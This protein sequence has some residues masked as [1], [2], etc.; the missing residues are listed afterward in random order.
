[1]SSG[2]IF[3]ANPGM[4]DSS[5]RYCEICGIVECAATKSS[6]CPWPGGATSCVFA[7]VRGG[8]EC[9]DYKAPTLWC[10]NCAPIL[11]EERGISLALPPDPVSVESLGRIHVPLGDVCAFLMVEAMRCET[12]QGYRILRVTTEALARE[13]GSIADTDGS[14]DWRS[15][16]TMA[17]LARWFVGEMFKTRL[18]GFDPPAQFVEACIDAMAPTCPG[19][20]KTEREQVRDELT[21]YWPDY[22]AP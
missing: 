8:H 19:A 12:E 22:T 1:M 2:H 4:F 11:A 15:E 6:A 13:F 21:A 20:S 10:V 18:P 5:S 7:V 16:T 3:R 17:Y 14:I 9:R